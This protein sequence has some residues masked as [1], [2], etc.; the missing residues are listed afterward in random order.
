[1]ARSIFVFLPIT[2]GKKRDAII[3]HKDSH[4]VYDVIILCIEQ[5][6]TPPQQNAGNV[7]LPMMFFFLPSFGFPTASPSHRSRPVT[8]ACPRFAHVQ[9]SLYYQPKQGIITWEIPQH[10]HTF[11]LFDSPKMGNLMTSDVFTRSEFNISIIS[12]SKLEISIPWK[13]TTI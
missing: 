4:T 8:Q 2:R 3:G 6:T 10:Y 11:V 5:V 13:S 9:G 1:M 12:P 7:A